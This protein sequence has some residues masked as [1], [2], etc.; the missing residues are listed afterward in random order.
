VIGRSSRAE[1]AVFILLSGVPVR[2]R[3]SKAT[4]LKE[5]KLHIMSS[6]K[7]K[8]FDK[9]IRLVV[10]AVSIT[11]FGHTEFN[12]AEAQSPASKEDRQNS[13]AGFQ[14]EVKA[15]VTK[16]LPFVVAV[17]PGGTGVI[18]S[19][20]GLVLSQA[21][22]AP[23]PATVIAAAR[24]QKIDEGAET[25]KVYL[26]D[27]SEVL[28]DV[29]GWDTL[30]DLSVLKLRE[31]GPYPSATFSE[32][33]PESGSW[34]IKLGYPAPL[35]YRK[36]QPAQVRLGKVLYRSGATFV[37]DCLTNGGDSGGPYFDLKGGVVGIIQGSRPIDGL[38]RMRTGNLWYFA[39]PASVVRSHLDAMAR[40]ERIQTTP[41]EKREF[42]AG[43]TIHLTDLLPEDQQSQGSRTL[44]AFRDVVA[45]T[46]GCV[47]EVLDGDARVAFGTVVDAD[48]FVLTK[49]SE[50]PDDPRCRL[51]DGRVLAVQVVGLDPAYDL[52][53]LRVPAN[54]LK[55]VA[56]AST[57][58]TSVGSLVLA[59]NTGQ[60]PLK[61]GSVSMPIQVFAGPFST[62]VPR[63]PVKRVMPV[64]VVRSA[65]TGCGY[66]VESVEGSAATV[67]ILKGDLLE[68]IA[69]KPIHSQED[70][71]NCVEG[72]RGGDQ[73]PLQLVRAGKTLKLTLSL[74]TD[75]KTITSSPLSNHR[76]MP[77]TALPVAVPV[78]A[79]ECG[80][81]L[82]G[83]DGKVIGVII[84]RP[85]VTFALVLPAN[86]IAERLK[87]LKQGLPCS[88][89]PS[90]AVC[91]PST[92]KPGAHDG[93]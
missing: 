92:S 78:A 55:L 15:A 38:M 7:Q 90:R 65:V 32:T 60:L 66:S 9:T 58:E 4:T 71:V 85:A 40:G 20:N 5:G 54:N 75:P 74:N 47:V 67:G 35:G 27:G 12:R 86:L 52:A 57:S 14:D 56:W 8:L 79:D 21:H 93:K 64:G 91:T 31:P 11:F 13:V 50:V 68:S 80:G 70:V 51:A 88:D 89:L 6:T 10:S 30:H 87:D 23:G 37:T 69:G 43:K 26:Q 49:A 53:L 59:V 83:L 81:P 63:P 45:S 62:T 72:R 84:G 61:L 1:S 2:I 16:V 76:A 33:V 39:T 41:A 46:K 82:V 18:I 17:G 25:T 3:S 34:I 22:V 19:A 44:A 29:L 73:L 42:E 77:P 36:G 24:G 48:G 28:A